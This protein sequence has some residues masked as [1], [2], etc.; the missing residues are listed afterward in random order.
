MKCCLH[1]ETLNA[2]LQL[3][4]FSQLNY[5]PLK[6]GYMVKRWKA[7]IFCHANIAVL[8][9]TDLLNL[10]V[11]VT[12]KD[13]N[14]NRDLTCVALFPSKLSGSILPERRWG[15]A[16]EEMTASVGVKRAGM[17]SAECCSVLEVG[18]R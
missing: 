18:H 15:R 6:A 12:T 16:N 4:A 13:E 1:A 9:R 17:K 8:N 7:L 2:D 5:K 10:E 14:N 11:A 3:Q